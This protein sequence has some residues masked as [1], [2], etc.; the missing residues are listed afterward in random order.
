MKVLILKDCITCEITK[1][2]N[3]H[4][5]KRLL[6]LRFRKKVPGNLACN[7]VLSPC[8]QKKEVTKQNTDHRVQS[9]CEPAWTSLVLDVNF[10][11]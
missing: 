7:H 8:I 9:S 11:F 3:Q 6:H 4:I 2:L 10:R 5:L 1:K